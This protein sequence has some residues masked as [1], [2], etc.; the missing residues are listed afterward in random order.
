MSNWKKVR[1]GDICETN[2]SAYS[3]RDKWSYINYLDTGN[4]TR[5]VIDSYQELIVG[6]DTIPSRAKRKIEKNDIVFSNVRPNQCHYG[7][8]KEPVEHLVVSTGFTTITANA[9]YCDPFFLYYYLTQNRIIEH[10]QALAEQ[11]VSTYPSIKASDIENLEVMLPGLEEQRRIAGIL[12]ALDDKIECNNRIN[13][14]LEEQAA[15]LFR[16]WFVDFE[17]PDAN[18]KPYR[19]SGGPMTP[20]PLGPI[21]TNWHPATFRD[22]IISTIGGDW[23]KENEEA[24]HT[25]KVYCI[26]GADITDVSKGNKGKMPFRY[27]LPKN[28][29]SKKLEEND[30]VVEVS[31]GSPTQSTGRIALISK[32]LLARYD[33]DMI[34]TNFCR[35]IKPIPEYAQYI[36]SLWKYLYDQN[37]MFSYENGTTGIK[38]L[39]INS[40]LD[41]EPIIVPPIEALI[42]YNNLLE[43]NFNTI[44]DNALES[45]TLASIRDILLPKLMNNEI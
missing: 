2:K 32:S 23:G 43:Q 38:N 19:S 10:L 15:A 17:F 8:I 1:L 3:A 7:I 6:T 45:D 13:R 20:S 22:I 4:I 24:N 27:I 11:T 37:T 33:Q 29:S 40:L 12:G 42:Q 9:K 5:N 36:Y 26:R 14:N 44:F 18:G 28:H 35:A 21:P 39:D 34:C 16:R 41:N 30:L 25:Q 31:G